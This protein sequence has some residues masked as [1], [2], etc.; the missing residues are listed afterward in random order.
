LGG[1]VHKIK[2]NRSLVV[3]SKE[4]GLDV[5]ADKT[6]YEGY[7]E[8]KF[9]LRIFP[10]QRCGRETVPLLSKNIKIKMHRTVILTVVLYGYENW[11][12][13]LREEDI[14]RMFQNKVLK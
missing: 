4:I 2:K 9:R 12:V 10:L 1:S 13:T 5:N 14:L 8:N 11:S 7:P 3:S 6:K